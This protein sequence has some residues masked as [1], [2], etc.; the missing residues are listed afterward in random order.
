MTL[1]EFTRYAEAFGGDIARWPERVRADAMQLAASPEGASILARE[2]ALDA[3]LRDSVREVGQARVDQAI[4]R[5]V[6]RLAAE[7]PRPR[8]TNTWSRWLLPA[9]GLACAVGIGALAATIG[10]L[11]DS[12]AEDAPSVLTMILDMTSLGQGFVL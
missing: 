2:G 4:H 3:V 12:G 5:V 11:A 10:P 8:L 1:Q 9:A 7:R 6:T